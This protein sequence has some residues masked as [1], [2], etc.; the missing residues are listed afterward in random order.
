MLDEEKNLSQDSDDSDVKREEEK[1]SSR[2]ENYFASVV[3]ECALHARLNNSA[4]YYY[5]NR[6]L[7]FGLLATIV[8][9]ICSIIVGNF[10]FKAC[11]AGRAGYDWVSVTCLI[12]VAIISGINSF[13]NFGQKAE[14]HFSC[15]ILF[16]MVKNELSVEMAK[17]RRF[18]LAADVLLVK[19]TM[20]LEK[21]RSNEQ[22][23][24]TAVLWAHRL[25]REKLA[26][27]RAQVVTSGEPVRLHRGTPVTLGRHLIPMPRT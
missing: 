16:E 23:I 10:G 21:V 27:A 1:W 25:D 4:G 3:D 19:I 20:A 12:V 11:E 9:A 8:P 17:K 24:P 2:H 5:Y 14:R 18:R 6:F 26:A 22:V 15:E 7:L 13:F